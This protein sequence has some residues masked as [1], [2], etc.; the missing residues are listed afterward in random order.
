MGRKTDYFLLTVTL[1]LI[2][3][4]LGMLYSTSAIIAQDRYGDSLYFFKRQLLWAALGFLVMMGARTVPYRVQKR[5]VLPVI[6]VT[7][8][9]L[10]AVL[11]IGKEVGGAQRW[12]VFGPLTLQ[13][14]EF[15]KYALLLFVARI[16]GTPTVRIESF[17]ETFFPSIFVMALMALLVFQ[18][19]DLG[20]AVV[21]VAMASLLLLIAGVPW[22]YLLLTATP[23]IPALIWVMV[24]S[25]YRWD[26]LVGFINPWGDRLGKGYQ[27]VQ[28]LIALGQGGFFGIGLGQSQQKLHYLPEAHTDFI[29]AI[30]G[31]ELGFV[32]AF[33][34][35]LL[36]LL[37]L[38]RVLRIA[39]EC[40][41]PFGT[42]LG[43]GIFILLALQISMNLGVVC[44]LL[45]TKGLPLPFISLGGS[46]LLISMLAI[47][48]MLNIAEE[49]QHG[50]RT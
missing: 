12:L 30:I 35:I 49:G 48:T 18:Q 6:G 8:L 25:S 45:P 11:V 33:G 5:L 28:S 21:L 7:L 43:L 36:F 9:A 17:L 22:K 42:Y 10:I 39:L 29:F 13:P 23:A 26:R 34:L 3:I 38:W 37:L 20:S 31:E 41:E 15:S 27:A 19:P 32:G 4:G 47:G 40:R 46:N 2:T 1:I 50:L 24:H 16:L 44:G 14:S